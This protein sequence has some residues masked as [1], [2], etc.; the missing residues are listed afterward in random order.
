MPDVTE[1]AAAGP[2]PEG[3][4]RCPGCGTDKDIDDFGKNRR[5]KDGRASVCSACNGE[6]CS[7]YQAK[8]VAEALAVYGDSQ[9]DCCGTGRAAVLMLV[10]TNQDGTR[11]DGGGGFPRAFQLRKRG[12]PPGWRV[13]CANCR[14]AASRLGACDCEQAGAAA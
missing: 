9:C 6:R 10:S 1:T 8:I 12:W 5:A 2:V 7:A 3:M 4:K 14:L 13:L 11:G